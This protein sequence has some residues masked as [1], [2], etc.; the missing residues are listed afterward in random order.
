MMMDSV[1]T[2]INALRQFRFLDPA[3]LEDLERTVDGRFPG[4]PRGLAGDLLKRQWLTPLQINRLFA[5]RGQELLVGSYVLMERLGEG[6]MGQV[7]KARNWKLGRVV[8]LKLIRKELLT[9]TTVVER[10]RREIQVTAQLD[11]PNIIRAFDADETEDGLFIVMEFVAGTDLGRLIQEVGPL[12]VTQACDYIRQAGLGLQ[13]AHEKGLIHRDIKPANLFRASPGHAIKLLDLGLARLQ[14]QTT[15]A[16]ADHARPAL[17]QI[18]VIVGT[19]DFIAPEQARDS[20]AVDIRADL[21]SLGCT[22][23]YL[24]TGKPPFPGGTATEKLIKHTLDPVPPLRHVPPAVTAVIHKLMAKKVDDRYQTPVEVAGVLTQLLAKPEQL[25]AQSPIALPPT[26]P[27]MHLPPPRDP[28]PPPLAAVPSN[29]PVEKNPKRVRGSG[30]RPPSPP[31]ARRKASSSGRK[32]SLPRDAAVPVLVEP[33]PPI[34]PTQ[35]ATQTQAPPR[36]LASRPRQPRRNFAWVFIRTLVVVTVLLAGAVACALFGLRALVPSLAET[37]D[38]TRPETP[39]T[40]SIQPPGE[41]SRAVV[42]REFWVTGPFGKDLKTPFP[43]ERNPDPGAVYPVLL[44]EKREW[45]PQKVDRNDRLHFPGSLFRP[46]RG[47]F[48]ALAYICSPAAAKAPMILDS[49]DG[50]RVWLNGKLVHEWDQ[51]PPASGSAQDRKDVALKQ[52][53]NTV[54]VKLAS[55]NRRPCELS[56]RFDGPGLKAALKPVR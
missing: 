1:R 2:L 17:T 48:Y 3:Q 56:L 5:G 13:H 37:I 38:P 27:L 40:A 24:L 26:V 20:S 44:G 52:G 9:N 41:N 8:A 36:P 31:P 23:Y 18:G 49:P 29:G 6:G 34:S 46:E 22:F 28:D 19:V 32:P 53:W 12:S 42:V 21:Y 35:I 55:R 14:E 4:D 47:C 33:P 30:V 45:K 15:R 50:I 43:P 10:F 25:L 16:L 39:P 7:F 11:H 51:N 54:L